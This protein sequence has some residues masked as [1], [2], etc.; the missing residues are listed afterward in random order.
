MREPAAP[1]S[2]IGGPQCH[3]AGDSVVGKELNAPVLSAS[4][5]G[6]VPSSPS[7]RN[8]T[9]GPRN[10]PDL[11]V[12]QSRRRSDAGAGVECSDVGGR[13]RHKSCLW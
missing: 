10:G 4:E 9:E 2:H 12:T 7:L 13:T 5:L 3:R 6:S 1:V 8:T 11:G